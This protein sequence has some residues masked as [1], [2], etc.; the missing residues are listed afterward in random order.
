MTNADEVWNR[1]ALEGG[2]PEPREGD[3]ALATLLRAHG[4]AMNGGV[5]RFV[6]VP[7]E[8]RVS[9]LTFSWWFTHDDLL[10]R[11][12]IDRVVRAL[13][14]EIPEALPRR[15]GLVKRLELA[16]PLDG[17]VEHRFADRSHVGRMRP[18]D[19]LRA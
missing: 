3:V 12:G 5:L 11:D 10:R 1:A 4:L 8:E 9:L 6:A 19:L 2:G 18:S 7:R 16:N 14:S 13:E 15:Y 17:A